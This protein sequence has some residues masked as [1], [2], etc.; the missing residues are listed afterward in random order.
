[1]SFGDAS[2][3]FDDAALGGDLTTQL[4]VKEHIKTREQN[5]REERSFLNTSRIIDRASNV[6]TKAYNYELRSLRRGLFDLHATT[7]SLQ[8][9][10]LLREGSKLFSMSSVANY[11][12]VNKLKYRKLKPPSRDNERGTR[13]TENE[14]PDSGDN[15]DARP[16]P[17][18]K[19][20][21]LPPL[22]RDLSKPSRKRNSA[23]DL[24]KSRKEKDYCKS[25]SLH[26]IST[27]SSIPVPRD[28]LRYYTKEAIDE[29][30]LLRNDTK[31]HIKRAMFVS[32][33]LHRMYKKRFKLTVKLPPLKQN[34][35]VFQSYGYLRQ[36]SKEDPLRE[37][38]D[39][40]KEPQKDQMKEN[41]VVHATNVPS[42]KIIPTSDSGSLMRKKR[43][44]V[45]TKKDKLNKNTRYD[46]TKTETTNFDKN[47]NS[48]KH[49]KSG[50]HLDPLCEVDEELEKTGIEAKNV[51]AET[52]HSMSVS[53]QQIENIKAN[54]DLPETI[55]DVHK[56][57][58]DK[59]SSD[60]KIIISDTTSQIANTELQEKSISIK[61]NTGS[62]ESKSFQ[63]KPS[64]QKQT[65]AED[66]ILT[67]YKLQSN[68]RLSSFKTIGD[69]D[70]KQGSR[71]YDQN[72]STTMRQNINR[73]KTDVEKLKDTVTSETSES[74]AEGVSALQS[75]STGIL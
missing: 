10:T 69:T 57:C 73:K 63:N 51:S 33:N 17:R 14:T 32:H 2:H 23:K 42:N 61:N 54:K 66:P 31:I 29:A 12:P 53:D 5:A 25:K 56:P 72:K 27:P 68:Y 74:E 67:K 64:Y 34:N 55:A 3:L 71:M 9:L 35:F 1:M 47:E 43:T 48:A 39:I 8:S 46:E 44:I 21:S 22:N 16:K 38:V 40:P 65:S 28:D 18:K 60:I 7:P 6:K 24:R 4:D 41:K 37:T 19:S 59:L 26:S 58:E 15:C 20:N 49:S 70:P 50:N 75:M 36:P 45:A 11:G 30:K 13:Q 52:N 62:I